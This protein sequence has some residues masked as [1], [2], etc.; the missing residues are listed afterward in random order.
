MLLC[1]WHSEPVREFVLYLDLHER[2]E[3][4]LA[5]SLDGGSPPVHQVTLGST[6]WL[7]CLLLAA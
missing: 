5:A 6:H 3:S 1:R 2:H 4:V 7:T